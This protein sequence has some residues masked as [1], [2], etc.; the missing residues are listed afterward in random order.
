[1]ATPQAH[2]RKEK[3]KQLKRKEKRKPTHIKT[4]LRQRKLLIVAFNIET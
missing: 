2:F 4:K 3:K 1:M